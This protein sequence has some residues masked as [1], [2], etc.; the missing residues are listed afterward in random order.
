MFKLLN[1]SLIYIFFEYILEKNNNY[2]EKI[3]QEH[4]NDF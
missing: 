1:I 3:I 4:K 2:F